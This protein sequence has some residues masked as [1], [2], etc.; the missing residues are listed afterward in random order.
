MLAQ[1]NLTHSGCVTVD[2]DCTVR[3]CAG[4][5]S[6]RLQGLVRNKLSEVQRFFDTKHANCYRSKG[7]PHPRV[8]ILNSARK[9]YLHLVNA[10]VS[11]NW[12]LI[13]FVPFSS[14]QSVRRE[15]L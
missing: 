1:L 15:V 2:A 13:V 11:P 14:L 8:Y 9:L 3:M 12:H 5:P 10:V 7:P 4:M 6:E